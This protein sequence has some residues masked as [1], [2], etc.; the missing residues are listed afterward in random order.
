MKRESPQEMGVL[1]YRRCQVNKPSLFLSTNN[2]PAICTKFCPILFKK[3]NP[4]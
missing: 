4:N 2:K 1:I 3:Q